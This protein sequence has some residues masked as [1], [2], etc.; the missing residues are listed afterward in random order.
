MKHKEV[1]QRFD[2]EFAPMYLIGDEKVIEDCQKSIKQFLLSELTKQED[3]MKDKPECNVT[4]WKDLGIKRGYWNFFKKQIDDE[5]KETI[6][7]CLPEDS[8]NYGSVYEDIGH[9]SCRQQTIDNFKNK[10]INL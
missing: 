1:L 4:A 2:D 5:W 7:E 3:E 6:K 8:H 10:G 9:N